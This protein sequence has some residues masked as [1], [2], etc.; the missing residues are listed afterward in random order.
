MAPEA[1]PPNPATPT[2]EDRTVCFCHC[3]PLS[4]ITAEIR[5]GATTFEDLQLKTACST[6]CGGCEW[7]VRD[8]LAAELQKNSA[9]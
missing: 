5:A 1:A 4:V 7:D 3:V 2:E 6:G 9:G 8:V